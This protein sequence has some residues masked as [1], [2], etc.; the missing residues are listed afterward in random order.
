MPVTLFELEPT[1]APLPPDIAAFLADAD[2]RI[3]AFFEQRRHLKKFGFYPSD[4]EMGYRMLRALRGV[5]DP[6]R[7]CEWGSG[8]AVVAGLGALLG[9]EAWAIEID[10]RLNVVARELLG[11]YQLKVEIVEGS[12]IPDEY[13]RTEKISDLDTVTDLTGGDVY[14]DIDLEIEDFDVIFAYP[15]PTEEQ[16]YCD[17]FGQF[18]DYG[19]V[20]VTYS[21]TEGMRT[22]R[23]VSDDS[24]SSTNS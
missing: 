2:A 11:D 17:L 6:Q 7:M 24:G 23:K 14:G 21:M 4:Y 18:A 20:M 12:F 3:D 10:P 15:W 8:F 1:P 13:A 19:A 9:Y 16:Q 5:T 22:Y